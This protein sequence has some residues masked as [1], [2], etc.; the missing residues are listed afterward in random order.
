M[1]ELIRRE[2]RKEGLE[3]I[4][5]GLLEMY[6]EEVFDTLGLRR[7]DGGRPY[8]LTLVGDDGNALSVMFPVGRAPKVTL[9]ERDV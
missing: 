3:A 9:Y 4:L 6:G 7:I 1:N 8:N 5:A 2:V